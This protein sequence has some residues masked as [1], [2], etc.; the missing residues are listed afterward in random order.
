MI[1]TNNAKEAVGG[2]LPTLRVMET[3]DMVTFPINKMHYVRSVSVQLGTITGR[4]YSTH[5]D[6]K[7]GVI[8]VTRL[9]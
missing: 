8:H 7:A 9:Q 1:E 6:R 5:I 2:I 4:R 3:G